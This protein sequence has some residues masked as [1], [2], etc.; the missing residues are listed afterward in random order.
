MNWK[1]PRSSTLEM[2][3][4]NVICA[5]TNME[6]EGGLILIIEVVPVS[7]AAGA[8]VLVAVVTGDGVI[9]VVVG[10]GVSVGVDVLVGV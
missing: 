1:A 2:T 10:Q 6:A 8:V 5:P 7:I 4:A 9:A 3:T